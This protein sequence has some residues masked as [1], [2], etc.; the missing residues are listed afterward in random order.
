MP[1]KE[2][3]VFKQLMI[4]CKTYSPLETFTEGTMSHF[5]TLNNN[6]KL[7][8]VKPVPRYI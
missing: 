7:T 4:R 1:L 5:G 6:G 8:K 3:K 2:R